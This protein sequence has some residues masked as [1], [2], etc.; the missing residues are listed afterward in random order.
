MLLL[1]SSL[2]QLCSVQHPLHR[3]S[4]PHKHQLPH[5]VQVHLVP[6]QPCQQAPAVNHIRSL[7]SQSLQEPTSASPSSML[8][9]QLNS[10]CQSPLGTPSKVGLLQSSH[11]RGSGTKRCKQVAASL[12]SF[13]TSQMS[14]SISSLQQASVR[15]QAQ[16]VP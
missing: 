12:A 16:V 3:A 11:R 9:H 7:W 6:S 2:R 15:L 5:T 1:H 10:Q 14:L 8:R 13:R 4:H